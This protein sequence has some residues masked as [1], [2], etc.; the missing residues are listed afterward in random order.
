MPYNNKAYFQGVDAAM[1]AVTLAGAPLPPT[2]LI[3]ITNNVN[4]VRGNSCIFSFTFSIPYTPAPRRM[5]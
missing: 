5:R 4:P 1:T 2:N 3:G